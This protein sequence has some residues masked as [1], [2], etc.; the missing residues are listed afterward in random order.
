V[1]TVIGTE[2]EKKRATFLFPPTN[3]SNCNFT[4]QQRIN[5]L[6]QLSHYSL[7]LEEM[8][9][10]I[11]VIDI[12]IPT[13]LTHLP[14]ISEK[15]ITELNTFADSTLETL[16]YAWASG[17]TT[18]SSNNEA[19]KKFGNSIMKHRGF[20]ITVSGPDVWIFSPARNLVGDYYV[21]NRVLVPDSWKDLPRKMKRNPQ[22][23][24]DG[25]HE[26]IE[27]DGT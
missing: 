26:D 6:I 10:P 22:K 23:V 5:G 17:N 13:M 4:Q 3:I 20:D 1:L 24:K 27:M 25:T 11:E 7:N 15:V 12:D 19:F 21:R 16:V 18:I 2:E 14:Q 8:V 9:L